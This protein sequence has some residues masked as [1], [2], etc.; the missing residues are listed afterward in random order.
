METASKQTMC[1]NSIHIYSLS[2]RFKI[3][4][5]GPSSNTVLNVQ[6]VAFKCHGKNR[7][8][9]VK[10]GDFQKRLEACFSKLNKKRS[11]QTNQV[12]WKIRS[13]LWSNNSSTMEYFP[14][15]A[16]SPDCPRVPVEEQG[17][18]TSIL[19]ALLGSKGHAWIG[20]ALRPWYVD[21]SKNNGRFCFFFNFCKK[22]I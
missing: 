14:D 6:S 16:T 11:L 8:A 9:R 15:P 19:N 1:L 18:G 20:S 13:I 17:A 5:L 2:W 10:L 7:R 22:Y 12:G 3:C 4:C 21:D